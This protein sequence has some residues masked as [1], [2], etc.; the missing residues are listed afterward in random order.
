MMS[1]NL[2]MGTEILRTLR[3][4]QD[5]AIRTEEHTKGLKTTI[6]DIQLSLKSMQESLIKTEKEMISL[7]LETGEIRSVK[8][9]VTALHKRQ[10]EMSLELRDAKAWIEAEQSRRDKRADRMADGLFGVGFGWLAQFVGWFLLLA[11]LGWQQLYK[12]NIPPQ[13]TPPPHEKSKD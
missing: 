10:D 5:N 9:A 6:E 1:D 3:F 13:I 2:D 12:P 11:Y 7:S 8:E 4:V